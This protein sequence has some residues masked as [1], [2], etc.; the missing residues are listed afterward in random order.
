MP[1]GRRQRNRRS[2]RMRIIDMTALPGFARNTA[3]TASDF[4]TLVQT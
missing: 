2:S 3:E 4:V 1:I